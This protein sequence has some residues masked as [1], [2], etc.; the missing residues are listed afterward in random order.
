[1]RSCGARARASAACKRELAALLGRR[2]SFKHTACQAVTPIQG[3]REPGA[4]G[5]Q[6]SDSNRLPAAQTLAPCLRADHSRVVC[7]E[8][9]LAHS[10][11]FSLAR[12]L[13]RSHA[14]ASYRAEGCRNRRRHGR[15]RAVGRGEAD[16]EAEDHQ[17]ACASEHAERGRVRCGTSGSQPRAHAGGCRFPLL[18][19]H[20]HATRCSRRR[21]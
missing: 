15:P 17:R 14:R 6:Q 5:A 21:G 18:R 19:R 9:V 4:P 1:M 20:T 3:S 16:G 12:E 8:L 13:V 10:L 11:G 7:Q 2:T